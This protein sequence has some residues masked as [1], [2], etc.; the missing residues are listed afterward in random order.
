MFIKRDQESVIKNGAKQVPIVAIIGPRQSGKSTIAKEIFKNHVYLDM[1]DAELFDFATKDPKGFLNTYKN[2]YG[3]II[4]EA[5]YVPMLFPQI[6]VEADRNPHPG[7]FVLSGS[8]N[9]LLH[10][11][12]NESLAGR[13][14]FYNL[15]PLSI[16]ELH[17]ADLLLEKA[18]DQIFKGFYPRVYQP[19]MNAREYY[20]NYISTYV[21]RDI[22]TIRNIDNILIF[23]KFM[24]ICA[25]RVGST[26]NI[27]DIAGKCGIS[28][29]T[30]RSWLALLETSFI[31]FL[32]PS[33]HDNLGKRLTKSPKLFFYDV[34]LAAALMGINKD[35][36]S[37]DRAIYGALFENMVIVDLI[38]SF[39]AHGMRP[40]LT[41]FR[42]SNQ[43]E[44]DLIIEIG[45]IVVP[46][47]IKASQTMS[48]S[49]YETLA[50]FQEQ[51]KNK[52]QPVVVY[53]GEQN[54]TRTQANVVGWKKL[55]T[56]V[57]DIVF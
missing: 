49:F 43:N 33:Y 30:A 6:K 55:D 5:Q 18:E 41:F 22:R 40:N 45:G 53:G 12:I 52:Q 15:L 29:S 28:E 42:D 11:K 17:R 8:Q 37:K 13:V 21:E 26:L 19:Q 38:K 47:E 32:L 3:I 23:K 25:L 27:A 20:E 35:V 36:I 48:S 4:D 16:A 56:I 1:Q 9:F 2:K 14:Y 24:Q 31:L 54:Q 44:I 51:T 46:V 7:Y 57:K 10:E 50:W 34:G 39:N